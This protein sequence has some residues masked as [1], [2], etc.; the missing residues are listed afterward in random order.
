MPTRSLDIAVDVVWGYTYTH[1]PSR[2]EQKQTMEAAK[3]PDLAKFLHCGK[4]I[5]LWAICGIDY[6]VFGKKIVPTLAIFKLLG[7]FSLL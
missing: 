6:L 3:W 7:I 5:S 4:E 2:A 1:L